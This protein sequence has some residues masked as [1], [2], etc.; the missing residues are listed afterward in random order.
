MRKPCLI[1]ASWNSL[2]WI[3]AFFIT[4]VPLLILFSLSNFMRH[5]K[6]SI[7][8]A[9]H[10]ASLLRVPFSSSRHLSC[11]FKLILN[12]LSTTIALK[13]IILVPQG[14]KI[15]FFAGVYR[16]EA[17]WPCVL[18][19]R[20]QASS[21]KKKALIVIGAIDYNRTFIWCA[22]GSLLSND[23]P[24]VSKNELNTSEVSE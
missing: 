11:R 19:M 3:K 22:Q 13:A 2:L 16:V 15:E 17:L 5:S 18:C 6:S 10:L 8:G 7:Y 23:Q 4:N 9:T 24:C 14:F 21:I 1:I 12:I 20:K